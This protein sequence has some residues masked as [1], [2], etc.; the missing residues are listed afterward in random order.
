MNKMQGRIVSL[1]TNVTFYYHDV[2]RVLLNGSPLS[3]ISSGVDWVQVYIPSGTH[4]VELDLNAADINE[5]GDVD[6]KDFAILASQ[7]LKVPG[8]PSADIA[9]AD[10][11]NFVNLLDLNEFADNWLDGA[12][13]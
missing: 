13:P 9:P 11:D 12:A 10:G 3:I 5:D 2:N 1:G 8:I 6:F 4:E 7:W